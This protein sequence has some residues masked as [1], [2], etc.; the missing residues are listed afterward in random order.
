MNRKVN[1]LHND[2]APLDGRLYPVFG[3]VADGE[4]ATYRGRLTARISL[5][6]LDCPV[7]SSI[8]DGTGS[9]YAMVGFGEDRPDRFVWVA[10]GIDVLGVVEMLDRVACYGV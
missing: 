5:D 10:S 1:G 6:D 3:G 8:A 4:W 7:V 9:V 2:D